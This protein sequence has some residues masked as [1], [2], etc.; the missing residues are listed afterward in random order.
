MKQTS[1][2]IYFDEEFNA[3]TVRFEVAAQV[4]EKANKALTLTRESAS[5]AQ[6]KAKKTKRPSDIKKAAAA[7]KIVSAAA[8]TVAGARLAAAAAKNVLAEA[9]LNAQVR[10]A[11]I[12]AELAVEQARLEL[13]RKSEHDLQR[14]TRSFVDGWAKQRSKEDSKKLKVAAQKAATKVLK[15]QNKVKASA[16]LKVKSGAKAKSKSKSKPKTQ[17]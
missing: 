5:Q 9:K 12:E 15:A 13:A 16:A 14:A 8:D 4:L 6:L 2:D 3:A 7:R 11:E 1:T 17:R 10:Q